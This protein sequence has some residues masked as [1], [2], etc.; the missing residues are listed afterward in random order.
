MSHY[1][2]YRYDRHLHADNANMKKKVN[3]H[4]VG[5]GNNQDMGLLRPVL[6]VSRSGQSLRTSGMG[7]ATVL[8]TI[9]LV[10]AVETVVLH[11]YI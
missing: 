2:G 1:S 7:P 9:Y 3:K 11:R 6:S 4:L 8:A 5:C 10:V